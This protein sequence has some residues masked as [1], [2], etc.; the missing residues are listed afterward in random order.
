M[1]LFGAKLPLG[2]I[3]AK[4][5]LGAHICLF[6]FSRCLTLNADAG[7]AAPRISDIHLQPKHVSEVANPQFK[8]LFCPSKLT[9]ECMV[10]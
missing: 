7:D 1:E 9:W 6:S 8:D 2:V 3:L 5:P 4:H 10:G